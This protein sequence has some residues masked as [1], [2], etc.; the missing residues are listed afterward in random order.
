LQGAFAPIIHEINYCFNLYQEDQYGGKDVDKIIL[1]GGTAAL[2]NLTTHLSN[3]LDTRVFVGDPWVRV[4]YPPEMKPLLQD[5]GAK[6]AI[7]IGLA[8]RD[9]D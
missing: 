8:M 3:L 1:A 6:F 4:V 9:I 7:S 2:P 5:I